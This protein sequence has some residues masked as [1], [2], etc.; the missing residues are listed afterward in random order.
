MLAY[1][2]FRAA[3][4]AGAPDRRTRYVTGRRRGLRPLSR[5]WRRPTRSSS[6]ATSTPTRPSTG[7]GGSGADVTAPG[8]RPVRGR[9]GK[10]VPILSDSGRSDRRGGRRRRVRRADVAPS[11]T[12]SEMTMM[13]A[14]E[15]FIGHWDGYAAARPPRSPNNYYLH[16]DGNG[17]FRML[18]WGGR[19]DFRRP[20]AV[21]RWSGRADAPGCLE[22]PGL[23]GGIPGRTWRAFRQLVAGLGPR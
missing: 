3:G 13:W 17:V 8:S 20:H 21:R 10:R 12:S 11:P 14:V 1:D 15:R 7:G 19:S 9:R 23:Q 18:P 22:D 4:I 2:V 6:V 5:T 16:S